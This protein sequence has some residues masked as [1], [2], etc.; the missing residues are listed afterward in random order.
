MAIAT[1]TRSSILIKN[2]AGANCISWNV[3][4]WR[5]LAHRPYRAMLQ[6]SVQHITRLH[7]RLPFIYGCILKQLIA[8]TRPAV[9]KM[10]KEAKKGKKDKIEYRVGKPSAV[11]SLSK[12]LPK[13]RTRTITFQSSLRISQGRKAPTRHASLGRQAKRPIS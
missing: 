5:T 7:I 3:K 13:K 4:R 2:I 12:G 6:S 8:G 1:S 11:K 9:R 10:N